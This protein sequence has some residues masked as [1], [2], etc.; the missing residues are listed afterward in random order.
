M[1]EGTGVIADRNSDTRQ[2]L[3]GERG[4]HV[5]ESVTIK[6]PIN[7][8][9]RFWRDF[10]NLPTLMEHLKS[11]SMREEGVS[12]WVAAGPV[13]VGVEWDARVINDV[14]DKVIGWQSLTGSTISTAG[15]VNFDREPD[16]TRVTVHFQY[17]P[18]G[19]KLG[20]AVAGIFGE[21]P[22]EMVREDL[23]RFKELMETGEIH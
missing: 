6:R 18:P 17:N 2:Q 12:H 14:P 4:I 23:L 19:G 11:V 9:Y 15:S 5:L 7:E 13:G 3:G 20:A 16:G 10:E 8:L 21:G 1:S 22:N